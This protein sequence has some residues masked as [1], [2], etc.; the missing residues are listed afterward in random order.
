MTMGPWA[1]TIAQFPYLLSTLLLGVEMTIIVTIGG[2]MLAVVLGLVGAVMR[3]TRF[4]M[5]RAVGTV[6]VDVFRAIPVLTQLFIIYFGLAELGIRLAPVPAAIIGFGINGGAY[7]TEVFRAGIE[8]VHRGQTE[9][10]LSIGMTRMQALRIIILPQA[11]RVILPPLGNFAI[12]LLKDTSVAS[13]VAA[14]EL[15]FRARMLVDQ[16]YLSTQIYLMVAALYLLM[17]LPLAHLVRRLERR[18][19]R[20]RPA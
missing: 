8:A 15:T 9:A 19:A 3:T 16:T 18:G 10:A 20:E 5:L 12:G 6:Y 7:L 1:R 11:M 14:P 2:F 13:S 4:A 17:S